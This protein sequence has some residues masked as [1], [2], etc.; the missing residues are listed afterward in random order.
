MDRRDF[1]K[2]A[3]ISSAG[4]G[5]MLR[6]VPSCARGIPASALSGRAGVRCYAGAPA[7]VIQTSLSDFFK[8]G[9]GP[10]SSHTIAPIRIA[11][12]FRETLSALPRERL[13]RG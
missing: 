13:S 3:L 8:I 7:G 1:I 9:P 11:A 10:S 2:V 6:G 12:H 5:V 4:V